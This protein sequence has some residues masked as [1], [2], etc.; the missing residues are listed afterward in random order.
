YGIPPVG[1][2][3]HSFVTTFEQELDAFTAYAASFPDSSIFL[4]DTYDT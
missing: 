1:T 4:V 2:M 3:A